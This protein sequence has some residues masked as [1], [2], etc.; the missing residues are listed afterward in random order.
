[1]TEPI[2]QITT[3]W[4]TS[5][6]YELLTEPQKHA[7]LRAAYEAM[8]ERVGRAMTANMPDDLVDEF[9]ALIDHP[10]A[11]VAEAGATDW[12]RKNIPGYRSIVER[13]RNELD[14]ELRSI[15]SDFHDLSSSSALPESGYQSI[16][17][18]SGFGS[19]NPADSSIAGTDDLLADDGGRSARDDTSLRRTLE[20]ESEL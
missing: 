12:L 2:P 10:D 1:M 15:A 11:D 20:G 9:A 17:N 7:L 3:D 4:L 8:E 16:Q 18:D 6:G 13:V 5:L 19:P 14:G